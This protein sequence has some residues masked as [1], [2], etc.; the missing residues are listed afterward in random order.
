MGLDCPQKYLHSDGWATTQVQ[1]AF[2]YDGVSREL[3]KNIS[4]LKTC[5]NFSSQTWAPKLCKLKRKFHLC[6]S[7]LKGSLWLWELN[8]SA[9]T[10]RRT[11]PWQDS[12]GADLLQSSAAGQKGDYELATCPHIEAISEWRK[13]RRKSLVCDTEAGHAM[14][15]C[16]KV[17]TRLGYGA[18]SAEL[19]RVISNS[20]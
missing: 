15:T 11:T 13:Q 10:W 4:S 20:R 9:C 7:W 1:L 8:S 19:W 12:L 6:V 17:L 2:L 18:N 5:V 14:K 16:L 3:M